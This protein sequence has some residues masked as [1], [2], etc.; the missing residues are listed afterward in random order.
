[1]KF[2]P[3]HNLSVYH[4]IVAAQKGKSL[5]PF[6]GAGMS[7]F[8]GYK[9]W[10]NVLCELA[11]FIQEDMEDRHKAALEQIKNGAYEEAAQTILEAYPPMLDQLPDLISPDKL[12]DCPPEKLRTSAVFTLP[13]LFQRGLVITTNFDRVLESIYQGCRDE[14]IQT[15]T[16]NQQDRMAQLRQ[17]RSLGLFKLHGDIGSDTV[18]IDD[19]VFTGEQYEEK[20]AKGSP[21]VQ[22][23]TRW[24]ENHRLLFL[25]CSLNVDRTMEVLKSVTLAQSGIRHYAILGCKKSDIS[26]RLRELNDLGILPIFYDDR[27]HDAVRVILERLLEETDQDAYKKLR[28]AS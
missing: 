21:L 19:L 16:P 3:N 22:E 15:V 28:T 25:G 6:V 7:V 1:M 24:F 4:K 10:G 23:L 2:C 20:Y 27:D 11:E 17:N 9:L 26:K 14:P 12:K 8:C 18:S 13:Y 5:I